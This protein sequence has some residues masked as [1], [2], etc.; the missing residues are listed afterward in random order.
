M[1]RD[2]AKAG[3]STGQ[4]R[5]WRQLGLM[6]AGLLALSALTSLLAREFVLQRAAGQVIGKRHSAQEAGNTGPGDRQQEPETEK[7]GIREGQQTA[8]ETEERT[9][10]VDE[11][12]RVEG[13]VAASAEQELEGL[14]GA[15]MGFGLSGFPLAGGAGIIAPPLLPSDENRE[16]VRALPL[17]PPQEDL[18]LE[19][20]EVQEVKQEDPT[21]AV[22]AVAPPFPDLRKPRVAIILDDGGYGG[23]RTEK[24]LELDPRLTLAILPNTPYARE[25]A[26]RG[27]A[28]GFEI[29]LHMPMETYSRK[30]AF[31][32]QITTRME[33]EE[34]E[35]LTVEALAQVPGV[36]GVNNHTGSKFTRDSVK[37]TE[38]LKVVQSRSLFFIDSITITKSA[39]FAAAKT[40]GIPSA[41][42]DIFLDNS[43]SERQIRRQFKE[44]IMR[45]KMRGL[46][47][48]IGHFRQHTVD[49]LAEELP[50]LEAYGV[51][52]VHASEVVR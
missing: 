44:L 27:A 51:E 4:T 23:Q 35:R 36:V 19:S 21:G 20:T 11:F 28:K 40:L 39:A 12:E 43:S 24:L 10:G 38:F 46:A 50:K 8:G 37:M 34:I 17:L 45:A 29:M 22:L 30:T 49:V 48:G 5:T 7:G 15:V 1:A 31:P 9:E 13:A 3:A 41:Q 14:G 32:G 16:E 26:E 42:R 18:P 2:K 25:T 33:A 47:I 52:L 6:L